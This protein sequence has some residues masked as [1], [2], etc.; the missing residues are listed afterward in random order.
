LRPFTPRFADFELIFFICFILFRYPLY[1]KGVE[2]F[3]FEYG[4]F[5]LNKNI[6]QLL[7]ARGHGVQDLKN[8]LPNIHIL[9]EHEAG[10]RGK[11]VER[12]GKADD[13]DSFE[14]LSP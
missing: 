7:N 1:P 2:K 11:R 13:K 9:L 12:G 4:V 10:Q 3:R 14:I 6:E 8:T 5:L